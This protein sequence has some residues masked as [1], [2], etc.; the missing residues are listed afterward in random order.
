MTMLG[1]KSK[2]EIPKIGFE[3]MNITLKIRKDLIKKARLI[4]LNISQ[5]LESKLVEYFEENRSKLSFRMVMNFVRRHSMKNIT[6]E[7]ALKLMLANGLISE[8]EYQEMW[9]V[10]FEKGALRVKL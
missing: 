1:N 9:K 5:F 3:K 4:G 2:Y 7:E 10:L 6:A 8:G